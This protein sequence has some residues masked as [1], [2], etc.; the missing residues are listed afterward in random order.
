MHTRSLL[1]SLAIA[2]VGLAALP[3]AAAAESPIDTSIGLVECWSTSF[4]A[5]QDGSPEPWTECSTPACGCNCPYVGAGVVV[6]AAPVD[7]QVGAAAVT[8]GCQTAYATS[9][10]PADGNDGR[11]GLPVTVWPIVGGGAVIAPIN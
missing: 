1:T 8:S 6:E 7:E 5:Q 11:T 4:D 2:L 3:N 10:S 9:I